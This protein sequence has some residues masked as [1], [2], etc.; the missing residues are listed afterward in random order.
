MT[1]PW[2]VRPTQISVNLTAIRSNFSVAQSLSPGA[3]V[4]PT[5][6]SDAYG[7]GIIAVSK[8]LVAAGAPMLAVALVEEAVELREA[9]INCPILI[10]AGV[11]EESYQL[12]VDYSLTLCLSH[13]DHLRALNA[14]ATKP[15][16]FHL[17]IDTGMTRLG[18]SRGELP[19]ILATLRA[20]P[21]LQLEGI[22]TH[23]ACADIPGHANNAVQMQAFAEIRQTIS[24]AGLAPKLW[25]AANSGAVINHYLPLG[26]NMVRPGL[27]IYGLG[28][29]Q[30]QPALSFTTQIGLL[31]RVSAGTAISYGGRFVAQKDS[32]I[33]VL[34]VG[35]GDGYRRGLS[36]IGHVL[37]AGRRCPVVGT[38]CMDLV[39]IDVSECNGIKVGDE[40]T[41]IGRQGNEYVGAEELAQKIGTIS[42]EITCGLTARVP[43]HYIGD[44]A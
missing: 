43:R 2:R 26:Q 20:C 21:N 36:N 13:R 11:F 23:Y 17:E 8:T 6:K 16:P 1:Q 24:A 5:V 27:M 3:I 37:V 41:L 9:G 10:L 39:M 7:H 35:Y 30:V 32:I 12:A 33:A 18:C 31:R 22:M 44:Q 29:P 19:D 38:V 15:V 40:V 42:Y 4:C 34:P 25:H 28:S 14:H